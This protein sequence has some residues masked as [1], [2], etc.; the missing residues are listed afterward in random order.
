[1]NGRGYSPNYF[2]IED[3]M[4]T[5][6]RV[7]CK[8]NITFP[9]MGFLCPENDE[10]DLKEGTSINIPIWLAKKLS[11]R[12]M[13]YVS[14]EVPNSFKEKA[15]DVFEADPR[16]VDLN[17]L[18]PH[19]YEFGLIFTRLNQ[20]DGEIVRELLVKVFRERFRKILGWAI[21]GMK[22]PF[23]IQ[24]LD[25]TEQRMLKVG[26]KANECLNEWFIKL[27]IKLKPA[28]AVVNLKKRKLL[29]G[30]DVQF[31]YNYF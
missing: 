26:Q 17:R 18:N 21:N 12:Q 19:F 15:R 31:L 20:R 14:V 8:T 5:Q 23:Q 4:A 27:E 24:E 3:I 29:E 22:D 11:G 25:T 28:D 2:S 9:R 13:K 7:P 1:M 16:I 10:D 30:E 6:E